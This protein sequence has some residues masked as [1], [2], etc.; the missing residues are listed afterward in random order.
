MMCVNEFKPSVKLEN[1][2]NCLIGNMD[3]GATCGTS[4]CNIY[5]LHVSLY[6]LLDIK[7]H[8]VTANP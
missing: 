1:Y 6:G 3:L 2:T 5:Y 8:A 7:F 4:A